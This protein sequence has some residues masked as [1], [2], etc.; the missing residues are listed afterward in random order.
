VEHT[1]AHFT[2]LVPMTGVSMKTALIVD[3]DEGIRHIV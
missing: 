3:G 1:P 2:A